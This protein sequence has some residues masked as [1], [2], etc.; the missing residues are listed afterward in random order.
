MHLHK[1]LL[2]RGCARQFREI[3]S[4]TRLPAAQSPPRPQGA[5]QPTPAPPAL[6]RAR[7]AGR[8]RCN[9][10]PPGPLSPAAAALWPPLGRLHGQLPQPVGARAV[11]LLTSGSRRRASFPPLLLLRRRRPR[12]SR[13]PHYGVLECPCFFLWLHDER[14]GRAAAFK[15][16]CRRGAPRAGETGDTQHARTPRTGACLRRLRSR[17]SAERNELIGQSLCPPPIPPHPVRLT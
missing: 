4:S 17:P 11:R 6:S 2:T 13:R 15:P 8:E 10:R 1:G 16:H 14:R 5:L 9:P 12:S 7:L 3:S